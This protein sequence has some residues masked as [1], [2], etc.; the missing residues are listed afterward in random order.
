MSSILPINRLG[1]TANLIAFQ[2]PQPSHPTHIVIMTK[3]P[4]SSLMELAP[5]DNEL[6]VEVSQLVQRLVNQ[7]SLQ[8]EG[9]RLIVNG[10][11]Y[12]TFA[13]L[14]FHLI[15]GDDIQSGKL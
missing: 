9:Y 10:G 15:S 12:Q 2:H 5:K 13:Q 1:E 11:K 6:L 14:H 8:D 7:L 3:R 4:I